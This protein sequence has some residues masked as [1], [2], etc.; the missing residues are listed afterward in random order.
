[1]AW[2][3]RQATASAYRHADV[4]IVCRPGRS[5]VWMDGYP[6]LVFVEKI[7]CVAWLADSSFCRT[8]N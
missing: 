5:S 3:I 8:D 7:S 4:I 6:V 1:M 2:T